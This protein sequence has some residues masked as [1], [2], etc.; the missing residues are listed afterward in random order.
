MKKWLVLSLVLI[1]VG[2]L[3]LNWNNRRGKAV[4]LSVPVGSD[5]AP[6]AQLQL[7]HTLPALSNHSE[8][9]ME[10]AADSLQNEYV[11]LKVMLAAPLEVALNPNEDICTYVSQTERWKDLLERAS[12]VRVEQVIGAQHGEVQRSLDSSLVKFGK[13]LY[14]NT[15]VDSLSKAEFKEFFGES[16]VCDDGPYE[17]DEVLTKVFDEISE[18]RLDIKRVDPELTEELAK[19]HVMK[20]QIRA[21]PPQVKGYRAS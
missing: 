20:F 6:S 14:K 5:T 2:V 13:M 11:S 7:R 1:L 19:I 21:K 12:D 3:G 18:R 16:I 8:Y 17:W 15:K 9:E 10:F 4:S